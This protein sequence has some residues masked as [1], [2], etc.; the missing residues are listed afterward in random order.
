M[1]TRQEIY[2]KP[3]RERKSLIKAINHYI[4]LFA[5]LGIITYIGYEILATDLYGLYTTYSKVFYVYNVI[6]F[7]I[8]NLIFLY[9]IIKRGVRKTFILVFISAITFVLFNLGSSYI[10]SFISKNLELSLLDKIMNFSKLNIN[11]IYI[12]DYVFFNYIPV[13]LSLTMWA[14]LTLFMQPVKETRSVKSTKRERK[15]KIEAEGRA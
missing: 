10:G 13:F 3:R 6:V 14:I 8:L 7:M 4:A 12:K 1:V 9:S 11:D 15:A 2:T 5:L